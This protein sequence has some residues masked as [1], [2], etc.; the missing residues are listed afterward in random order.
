VAASPAQPAG[1]PL[2]PP[3]P[4]EPPVEEIPPV[5]G[6]PAVPPFPLV[7]ELPPLLVTPPVPPTE[8]PPVPVEPE[9]PPLPEVPEPPES[10]LPHPS[11]T[12]RTNDEA[13]PARRERIFLVLDLG[14]SHERTHR[15]TAGSGAR[16]PARFESQIVDHVRSPPFSDVSDDW[17]TGSP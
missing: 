11:R 2:E 17:R 4:G 10:E 1:V 14:G 16:I 13:M 7:A 3:V 12:K 8:A 6:T 15:T 5:L 9:A